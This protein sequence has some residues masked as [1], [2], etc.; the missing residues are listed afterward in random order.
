[1]CWV[2]DLAQATAPTPLPRTLVQPRL[3]ACTLDGAQESAEPG[4]KLLCKTHTNKLRNQQTQIFETK[5]Y[6]KIQTIF[7]TLKKKS[8]FDSHLVMELTNPNIGVL[9]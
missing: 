1:M 2:F 9:L 5:K 6:K 3:A 7:K 8:M 4:H